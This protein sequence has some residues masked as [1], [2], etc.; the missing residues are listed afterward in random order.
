VW[1]VL[2]LCALAPLQRPAAPTAVALVKGADGCVLGLG[3]AV[4]RCSCRELSGG[5]RRL[6]GFP[7][8]LNRASAKDLEALPGIGVSRAHTIVA[9]RAHKG[10]FLRVDDLER[11]P[12]LGPAS[13]RRIRPHLFVD[14][15]DPACEDARFRGS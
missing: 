9:A 11:L 13:V 15:S 14:G 4:A 8:P 3:E 10:P 2:T 5:L 12:G 1:A 7:I 6:F